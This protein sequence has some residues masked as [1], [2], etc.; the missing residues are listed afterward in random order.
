MSTQVTKRGA[1]TVIVDR[2]SVPAIMKTT[3]MK[4]MPMKG[5]ILERWA[6]L[7]VLPESWNMTTSG[8]H[9]RQQQEH[10]AGGRKG[11]GGLLEQRQVQHAAEHDRA[12]QGGQREVAVSE[13][14]QT[15]DGLAGPALP[16]TKATR[17]TIAMGAGTMGK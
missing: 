9:H 16:I 5:T 7:I 13:D 1:P 15:Q 17:P 8:N 6:R 3:I 2:A 12:G 4:S 10:G 14:G 11:A